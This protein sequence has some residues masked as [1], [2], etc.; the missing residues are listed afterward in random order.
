MPT[1]NLQ[2]ANVHFADTGSGTRAVIFLHGG[3]G[4]SSELWEA[5][6]TALPAGWRGFALDNFLRS[7]APPQGYNVTALAH[8]VGAFIDA[9]G[10]QAPVVVGHSMGGVV[11]QLT[12]ILYPERVG[13]LV[14]VC[15][16]PSAANHAMAHQWCDILAE[17]GTAALREISANWFHNVPEAFFEG[18]VQRACAAP[19]DAMLAVQRSLL[20]ADLRAELPRIKAPALVVRGAYDTGRTMEHMQALLD[21][22]ARSRLVVMADSGHSPMVET[23]H[24]F[25]AALHEF[26]AELST[27]G[28]H[29]APGAAAAATTATTPLSGRTA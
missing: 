4:S 23:P 5:S 27:D 14:L 6:M 24:D 19:L 18:Y 2:G 7:D 20:E 22:I 1:I 28:T 3:F 26:L 21:G 25:N 13:G 17:Q 8:R 29:D 12:G 9:L 16:G 11:A 15:T 10:L